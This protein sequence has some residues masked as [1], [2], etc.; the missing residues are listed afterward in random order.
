MC[1][2]WSISYKL[3]FLGTDLY[4]LNDTDQSLAENS[5]ASGSSTNTVIFNPH[6]SPLEI[7]KQTRNPALSVSMNQTLSPMNTWNPVLDRLMGHNK[8]QLRNESYY[9]VTINY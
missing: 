2:I 4:H 3:P 8:Q 5:G 9:K 1:T 6:K 7:N